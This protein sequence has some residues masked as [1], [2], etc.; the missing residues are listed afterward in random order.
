MT[1][2]DKIREIIGTYEKHGWV[3]RRL[4]LTEKTLQTLASDDRLTTFLSSVKQDRSLDMA[5]FSRPPRDGGVAWELRY[6]GE[7]PFALLETID[8]NSPDFEDSLRA[9][10]ERLKESTGSKRSSLT[11]H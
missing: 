1:E 10:E 6:L 4:M 11:S 5:W 3:L 7:P 8:E 2:P 9:V